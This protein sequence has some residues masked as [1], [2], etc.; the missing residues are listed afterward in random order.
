MEWFGYLFI[1]VIV[2]GFSFVCFSLT[3]HKRSS[4][5][6][7]YRPLYKTADTCTKQPVL[8]VKRFVIVQTPDAEAAFGKTPALLTEAHRVPRQD[9]DETSK[10]LDPASLTVMEQSENN[11]SAQTLP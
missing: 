5:I 10:H 8:Y 6:W 3:E 4:C 2:C 1:Q 11:R 7:G 9:A